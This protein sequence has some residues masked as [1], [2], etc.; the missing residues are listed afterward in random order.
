MAKDMAEIK[1]TLNSIS[2]T[3]AEAK[4]GWKVLMMFGGA[5]G[6]VGAML[7]QIIHAIPA[8]K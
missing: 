8:G 2:N 5:G 4:G 3:L 7:T 1:V 6:V